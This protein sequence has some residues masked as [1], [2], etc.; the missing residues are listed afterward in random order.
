VT[1]ADT[2]DESLTRDSHMMHGMLPELSAI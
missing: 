2:H 1:R